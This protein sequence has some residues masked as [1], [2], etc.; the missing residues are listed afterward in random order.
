M[1]IAAVTL[2]ISFALLALMATGFPIA[3]S[4][5]TV[6]V[7]GYLI[8]VGPEGLYAIVSTVFRTVT[9]DVFIAIPLFV[10]MSA[11][12]EISGIG[13]RMFDVM[14]KW[15]AGLRG[16]LAMGVIA[17]STILAAM[18]GVVATA[19]VMMGLLA[20][21]E[22]RKRNYDKL[23][24]IGPIMAGGALGP[25][26]PPS[27][28]AIIIGGLSGISTGKLFIAG[29]LPGLLSSFLFILY[30][31]IRCFHNKNLGPAIPATERASW[32]E[33]LVGLRELAAPILLILLI[34]GGIWTGVFTPSEAAGI[35]VAGALVCAFIF[36]NLNLKNLQFAVVVSF[37]A[38]AM[39]MWLTLTGAT[40]ASFY[41]MIGAS[42]FVGDVMMALPMG[43]VG[44]LVTMLSIVFLMGMFLD[45]VTIILICLP[46][47]MPVA[48]QLGFDPLWFGF[49]FML[50]I[51]IGMITP[52]FGYALFYFKGLGYEE[53][54]MSDIYVSIVPYVVLMSIVLILCVVFPDIA[55]WLPRMMIK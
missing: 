45:S 55:L 46:I 25:L 1:S 34:L 52:P 26:I 39:V 30:I 14:Y 53:V 15:M 19:T 51:I 23:T 43:S 24:A 42:R 44:I 35:G 27:L 33:K 41:G 36:R 40:F 3:F 21:P 22:M 5:L 17:I 8:F 28:P 20:Y 50:D 12:L 49:V 38:T 4:M 47:M 31:G 16:G 54:S 13:R 11:I 10:F 7:G 32:R 48:M 9:L 18:T 29:F 2:V 6:A 37:K